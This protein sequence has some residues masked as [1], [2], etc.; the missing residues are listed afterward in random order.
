MGTSALPP[1]SM[2]DVLRALGKIEDA[3]SSSARLSKKQYQ[4]AYANLEEDADRFLQN[5]LSLP[6]PNKAAIVE[7]IRTRRSSLPLSSDITTEVVGICKQVLAFGAAGLGLSLGFADKVTLLAPGLQKAITIAGIVYLELV[8]VSMLVLILYL[9]Q[10]RFR[11]P[12]L[13]LERIGNTWPWFYYASID[14]KVPRW[15]LPTQK[16]RLRGAILYAKDLVRFGDRVVS[17]D[18]TEELRVELQQY[19]LLLSY[20]GY[21]SQFSL[22][23]TNT[24]FYGVA[25]SVIT[26]AILTL[27]GMI[28]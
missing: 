24:F 21:V 18:E 2:D 14:P 9:L 5:L 17:E 23:L 13:S 19:F 26:G 1:S 3:V 10:A 8:L 16:S 11:Y 25:G 12:F 7:R 6:L 15:P 27:W 4:D 20:Q 22:R 28:K